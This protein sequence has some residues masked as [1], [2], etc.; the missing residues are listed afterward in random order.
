MKQKTHAAKDR[1]KTVK[2]SVYII[3]N[4]IKKGVLH[5]RGGSDNS[6]G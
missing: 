3:E 4:N 1:T 2:Y 5:K 6:A